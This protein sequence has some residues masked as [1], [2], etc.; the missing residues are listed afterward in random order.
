MYSTELAVR[1]IAVTSL[2]SFSTP[3]L[4][5]LNGF[6]R[7]VPSADSPTMAIEVTLITSFIFDTVS[8]DSYNFPRAAL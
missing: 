6:L 3:T 2:G 5:A 1:T 7:H 4:T 8:F